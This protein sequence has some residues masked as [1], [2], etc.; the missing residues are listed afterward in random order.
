MANDLERDRANAQAASGHLLWVR[1]QSLVARR[2]DQ[3]GEASIGEPTPLGGPVEGAPQSSA[4]FSVS[5]TGVLVYQVAVEANQSNLLWF[6]R[7]GRRLSQLGG[8]SDYSNLEASPDGTRLLV[9]MTDVAARTR[10]IWVLDMTR[11]VPTRLTFD[12]ADERSAVWSSDGR[13]IVYRGREGELFTRPL[14]RGEA[15]PFL[16]DKRS[17]D[18]RGWS[19]DGRYFL[20]RV[21]DQANDLWVKPAAPGE[22][23]YPFIA[24]TFNE[25]YGEFSPSGR[26]VAYVS[27]ESGAEEVYVTEFPSGLGKIRISSDGGRFPRWRKDEK[28]LYYLGADNIMM[29]ATLP[30]PASG[31]RVESTTALFQTDAVVGPAP[32]FVVSADG[33]RFLIN[34]TIPSRTPPTLSLVFN[35]PSLIKKR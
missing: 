5:H 32:P 6:D 29:A 23:A 25:A 3:L 31:L 11:G 1:D 22:A 28:E 17:K 18:P 34:S 4:A 8:D 10:D 16:A 21:T 12:A 26:W 27:D 30:N 35:W 9:S 19:S 20:Y 24:T 13:S 14:G 33:E 7:A 15:Q 2:L